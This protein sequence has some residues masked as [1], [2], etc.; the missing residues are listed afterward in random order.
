MK[1]L[2]PADRMFV[3]MES[4]RAPAHLAALAIFD[5]P[6][7]APKSFNRE[8]ARA[9]SQLAYLPFPF[10]SVVVGRGSRA[11]WKQT[12][13]DPSYHVRL[14]ALPHPGS[15]RDLGTLVEQLHSIPLDMSKPLW[16]IHII[17]GLAGDQFAIFFKGHHCATD[18]MGA[19]NCITNWLTTDPNAP[20]GTSQ[21]E[22]ASDDFSA[23]KFAA[24][25][26]TR[27]LHGIRATRELVPRIANI[28]AGH[29]VAATTSKNT[30]STIFNTR[31]SRHR[32]FASQVLNLPRVKAVSIAAGVTVNDVILAS[33][34]GQLSALPG[35]AGRA[36]GE[37]LT[38]WCRWA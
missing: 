4:P 28:I 34:G 2:S 21:T 16:E 18:G 35:G 29:D 8:L 22:P 19:I 23:A 38:A 25:K 36:A 37:D 15:D 6:V 7:G 1:L 30:P 20:P 14:A 33:V 24:T 32:S 27:A 10:D 26:T 13:P 9:L 11:R 17:E 31:I 3:R 12:Q 5:L